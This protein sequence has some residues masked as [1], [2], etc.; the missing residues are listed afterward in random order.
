MSDGANG[1]DDANVEQGN[2]WGGFLTRLE[3]HRAASLAFDSWMELR[4]SIQSH[5]ILSEYKLL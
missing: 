4:P 2:I 5:R 3:T 1:L